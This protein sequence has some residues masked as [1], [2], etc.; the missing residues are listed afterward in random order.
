MRQII[1]FVLGV[2]LL[3]FDAVAQQDK[4]KWYSM[5]EAV[6]ATQETPKKLFIDVYT[7]WCGWCKK[8]DA[9]T[10][11]HPRIVKYLNTHFYPV[12]LN[13]EGKDPIKIGKQTFK[14]PKAESGKRGTHQL[15]A[16]L[17]N[18]KMSY[19]SYAFM[20]GQLKLLFSLPG[21]KRPADMEKYLVWVLTEAYKDEPFEDWVKTF[22][23]K[24]GKE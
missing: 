2:F 21:Y 16:A 8:M 3:T 20:D 19:P 18:G 4:V 17:L 6:A 1:V 12:K 10:F 13:A 5:E 7:T 24:I 15:A 9:T 11:K 14:N 22:E 23:G